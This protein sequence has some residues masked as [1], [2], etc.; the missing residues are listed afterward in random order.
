MYQIV[1][2]NPWTKEIEYVVS[3]YFLCPP[4]PDGEEDSKADVLNSA[5]AATATLSGTVGGTPTSISPQPD[6]QQLSS[7]SG[8]GD[9]NPFFN[10]QDIGQQQQQQQQFPNGLARDLQ[11]V[12]T[13]HAEAA[14]IGRQIAEE[15]QRSSPNGGGGG[16]GGERDK[17]GDRQDAADGFVQRIGSSHSKEHLKSPS[18]S[19]GGPLRRDNSGEVPP[20]RRPSTCSSGG[21][22]GGGGSRPRPWAQSGRAGRGGGGGSDAGSQSS[23]GGG[24]GPNDEVS[25][26]VMMSLLEAEGGL[27]GTPAEFNGHPWQMS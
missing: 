24:G 11:R 26:A 4:S 8:M 6:G 14:R 9:Q 20:N 17:R 3:R 27:G 18:S 2:R 7:Q 13:S 16:G 12:I 10:V 1:N 15:V 19:G 22:G 25:E 5:A 21:G 23:G